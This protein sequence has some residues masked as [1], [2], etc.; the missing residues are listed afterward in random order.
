M[1]PNPRF[2]QFSASRFLNLN[3]SQALPQTPT[4]AALFDGDNIVNEE[5]DHACAHIYREVGLDDD[6]ALVFQDGQN[7]DGGSFDQLHPQ[8]TTQGPIF[9]CTPT[10]G[11]A[12]AD[13]YHKGPSNDKE[14][15][16]D[17]TPKV[18]ES[19]VQ[20]EV[21]PTDAA[22]FDST[23]TTANPCTEVPSSTVDDP[24]QQQQSGISA[25]RKVIR[26]IAPADDIAKAR[27]LRSMFLSPDCPLKSDVV[28]SYGGII[29]TGNQV[30]ESFADKACMEDCFMEFFLKC[31]KADNSHLREW[32]SGRRVVISLK[33]ARL[34][35][36][37]NEHHPSMA[38]PPP[39]NKEALQFE[40][41]K[42]LPMKNGM[43]DCK[44]LYVPIID[45]GH[46]ILFVI[47]AGD[48]HVKVIDSNPY[49]QLGTVANDMHCEPRKMSGRTVKW[50]PTLISRLSTALHD[51]RPKIGI[52]KFGKW[53]FNVVGNNPK[54]SCGSN[55]YG[56]Y[57]M[58]YMQCYDPDK[59][60]F[61]STIIQEQHG[62]LRCQF[63]SYLVFHRCNC[64]E[65]LPDALDAFRPVL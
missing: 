12:S 4:S 5:M 29:A 24:K 59:S 6:S 28:M 17:S 27:Q 32:F 2:F 48:G 49:E 7:P 1:L 13:L 57:V 31:F 44:T 14:V 16:F 22:K 55:D 11:E 38:E 63:L 61:T 40:Q 51:A 60:I 9:D 46:W 45:R 54:M 23:P 41:E 64:V 35:N 34:L 52:P 30:A 39:F 33:A 47:N 3:N 15:L 19:D 62:D 20:I 42:S 8:N 65:K 18:K 53:P 25:W 36:W 21:V 58:K 37:E 50:A 43:K 56:F 26:I 10:L